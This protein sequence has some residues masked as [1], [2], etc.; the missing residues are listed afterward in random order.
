MKLHFRAYGAGPPVMILHGLFGSS[1]N[2]H[3]ISTKLGAQY[4][5]FAVDLRNHGQSPRSDEISYGAMAADLGELINDQ[6]VDRISIIGHSLGGKVAMQ[7]ALSWPEQVEKLVVVDMAPR[8]Y[9]PHHDYIFKALL[10]LDLASFKTRQEIDRA[11][12]AQIPQATVRQFLLKSLQRD[13]SGAFYWRIN[14]PA[15]YNHYAGL[16][17]ALPTNKTCN[18]PALFLKGEKSDYIRSEDEPMIRELFPQAEIR[19]LPGAGHW[20]HADVPESFFRNV[21]EFIRG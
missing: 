3:S 7:F 14:L 4:K 13:Q 1:D 17:A 11:I 2:W 15:L 21:Q 8:S 18:R 19:M 6:S 5:V 16:S 9:P 20:L 12:A 10:T